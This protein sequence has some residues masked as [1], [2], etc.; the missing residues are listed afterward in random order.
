MKLTA[1]L[2]IPVL[3][4][5]FVNNAYAERL[6][7]QQAIHAALEDNPSLKSYI[8][9]LQ[10]QTQDLNT[11]KGRLYPKLKIEER[12]QRTDNPTYSFMSKLNQER[13]AQE[14][15]MIESLND[16]ADISDFQTSF[17]FE[18]PLFVPGVYSGINMAGKELEA[19]QAEYQR[20]KEEV[21]LNVVKTFHMALSAKEYVKAANKGKEDAQ[22]HK[23]LAAL[24]YDSGL[25][26]H[27][28]VLR[29]GVAVKKAESTLVRA[30]S[31]L[32]V[33]QRALGLLL[34]RK[35]PLMSK[36]TTPCFR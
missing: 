34:G 31:N 13:F 32:E 5:V 29:A 6:T 36:G 1:K 25:G 18:Q 35:G 33:A 15:F 4:S 9:T 10:V 12:Y 24:R 11:A 28:D 8:W 2:L 22:E 17:S 30:E 20:K 23:R 3:L 7:L 21:V 19:K 26:L 27:S 14:D 16:P